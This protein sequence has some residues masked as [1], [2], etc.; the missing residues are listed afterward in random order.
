MNRTWCERESDVVEALR[1][2]LFSDEL[3]GH[4]RS[5]AVCAEAEPVAQML[6]QAA[7]LLRVE[8]EPSAAGLVWRRAQA[9]KK[10]LALK[11]ATRPL[12]IMRALSAGYVVLCAA[13]L[14]HTFWRTRS[15]E[16]LSGWNGLP[17]ETAWF[18]VAIA[19][20]ATAIG[21]W[22]LLHDGRRSGEGIPS[23]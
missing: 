16:F 1:R 4:V 17:A 18:G 21:A 23:T 9:R 7:S 12:I 14:L 22:Y 15:V 6:L 11:R 19:V 10:E 2:G 5:C 8:H 20:L 3:R 13:W